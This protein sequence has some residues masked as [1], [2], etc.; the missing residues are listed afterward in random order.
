[1][2]CQRL[3]RNVIKLDLRVSMDPNRRFQ[4]IPIQNR[5]TCG[6]MATLCEKVH[7]VLHHVTL[8]KT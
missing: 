8:G 6:A 1:M 4:R 2:S 7:R 3:A 5:L